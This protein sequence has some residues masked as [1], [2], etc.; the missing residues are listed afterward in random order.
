MYRLFM[1]RSEGV[2]RRIILGD[3]IRNHHINENDCIKVIPIKIT[4][5]EAIVEATTIFAA[6]LSSLFN[7]FAITKELGGAGETKAIK[8]I[9]NKGPLNPK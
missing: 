9:P 7:I 5:E 4:I 2:S 3:N 1:Y 6:R 8:I